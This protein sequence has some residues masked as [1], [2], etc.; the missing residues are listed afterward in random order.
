[1][2]KRFYRCLASSAN[3]NTKCNLNGCFCLP[4]TGV[5][6]AWMLLKFRWTWLF[7]FSK[8]TLSLRFGLA[9][10]E[11][12]QMHTVWMIQSWDAF[13]VTSEVHNRMSKRWALD[14]NVWRRWSPASL[15]LALTISRHCNNNENFVHDKEPA[16][17]LALSSRSLRAGRRVNWTHRSLH[18]IVF[19]LLDSQTK[20]EQGLL[21][22][23]KKLSVYW[24]PKAASIAHLL[25]GSKPLA[26][27]ENVRLNMQTK[28]IK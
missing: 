8:E 26:D 1:M 15:S 24:T 28:E 10:P 19:T 18:Y 16:V 4:I 12:R 23:P 3:L 14:F 27:N 5:A 13:A 7:G 9:S 20:N 2:A 22:Q 25:N 11:H 6:G 21:N 17:E